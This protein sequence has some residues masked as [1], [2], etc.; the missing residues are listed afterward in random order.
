MYHLVLQKIFVFFERLLIFKKSCDII[1]LLCEYGLL[2]KR[3][4]RRPLTAETGV[5]FPYGSPKMTTSE[6][7][8][9]D[10]V[11]LSKP[12][13]WHGITRQRVWHRPRRMASPKVYF[14]RLDSIPQQ[15]AGSI[16]DFV[17]IPY[18]TSC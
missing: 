11:I 17:A 13:A 14:L 7:S 10:V 16:R 1:P 4:R 9:S 6:L 12:Q 15:V 3:L 5:R 18:N 8:C 2:V